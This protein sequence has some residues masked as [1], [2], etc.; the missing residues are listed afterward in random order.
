MNPT[1]EVAGEQVKLRPDGSLFWPAKRTLIVADLHF[2]KS[3][4]FRAASVP[5]PGNADGTLARLDAS[6]Q[7]TN[8]ARLVVLGDFWHAREGRT[9][10]LVEVLIDWRA[11]RPDLQIELV[12]GNHDRA[13]DPPEGWA[14]DWQ[15]VVLFD[16]PFC[17]SHYPESSPDGYVLAGHLHPRITIFGRGR[18][19]FKLPCFWFGARFGVLP[20]FGSFT[21]TAEISPLRGDRVFAIADG[22]IV[23][24]PL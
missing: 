21:G 24:I 16:P 22:E 18:E 2:G 20:A 8:A 9:D 10:Q 19:L 3:D 14:S 4:A 12:R 11:A 7:A 1:L 17:F 6:L 13:G 23:P 5:V 15:T